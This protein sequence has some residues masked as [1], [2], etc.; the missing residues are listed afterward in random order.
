MALSD[1][2]PAGPSPATNGVS[3]LRGVSLGV[4]HLD[5]QSTQKNGPFAHHFGI[6]SIVLGALEVQQLGVS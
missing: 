4:Y 6:K 1:F 5:L 2:V 3:A